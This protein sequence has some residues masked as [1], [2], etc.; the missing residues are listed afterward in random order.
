MKLINPIKNSTGIGLIEVLITTVVVAVG[1]LAIASLQG[2][3]MNSSG[4]NKTH[5]EAKALCDTKVEELRDTIIKAG[6]SGYDAI[7][8]SAANESITG[9]NEIFSR[10][11]VVANLPNPAS[12]VLAD[13]TGPVRKRISAT[14]SWA[15]GQV[16]VQ[17]ILAFEDIGASGLD[18]IGQ[19]SGID[20]NDPSTN[21]NSSEEIKPEIID[22]PPGQTDGSIYSQDGKTYLVTASGTKGVRVYSCGTLTP[23][24]HDLFTRR[25]NR[26]GVVG[27]EA[28][29]LFEKS[30]VD[31]SYCIPKIRFNGGVIIPIRGIVHS[32]ATDGN[33]GPLLDVNLFT[34]NAT[35]SGTYCIFDP[36]VGAKSAPYV[37]YV[38]GNCKFGPAGTAVSGNVPV[39]ECPNPTFSAAK[40]GPGGWRGKVGLLGVAAND[41]NVCFAEELTGEP[42]T[43][44]TAR[45]YYTRNNGLNEGINKP[46]SCHDFLIINGQN[47]NK[48]KISEECTDQ[49]A[50][51]GGFSLASKNIQ[52]DI[53][54]NNVFDPVINTGYCQGNPDTSQ[55]IIGT[56]EN[57]NSANASTAPE[58]TVSGG[59]CTAT[60]T[61][62]TCWLTTAE[63]SVTVSGSYDGRTASC[64]FDPAIASGCTLS[65]PLSDNP[66]YTI[67]GLIN[68]TSANSVSVSLDLSGIPC[69][70]MANGD[71]TY[72][73]S[74]TVT[75]T[76]PTTVTLA[77]KSS[78]IGTTVTP[79]TQT[80]TL[81]GASGTTITVP[82]PFSAEGGA[83]YT[84]S[85]SI[86]IGSLVDNL[87]TVTVA[88]DT[89]MGACTLTGSHSADT[90]DSYSC[91][92]PGG[93]NH[94]TIAISPPCSSGEDTMRY[95]ISDG[96]TIMDGG[97]LLIDL[98][99]VGGPVSKDITITKSQTSC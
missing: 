68:G 88:V 55:L 67:T 38:G 57:A 27:D 48:R 62:Y 33:N 17:S 6:A 72:S 29:E 71:G 20:M 79:T 5:A 69:T 53:T 15:S 80:V 44:D 24:E 12:A 64:S 93:S 23:F 58:V 40:V 43:L 46:Y 74:C 70:N 89:N 85:G 63:A 9:T 31:T 52:R 1:L 83:T 35:E 90:A 87:T 51:I 92:V 21:A 47:N 86:N 45:N 37:C 13:Q 7:A 22:L 94:L 95:E 99:N 42:A 76:D 59:N 30:T 91:T 50:A 8:S 18:A 82:D 84:V 78:V 81:S 73:Y 39:T 96:T 60:T 10:G 14:C 19:N 66:T 41:K 25:V 54:G 11:W 56:I 16:V 49:A 98:G 36:I 32:A 28:I 4:L 26:D 97:S 77:A 2:D 65:F 61:S 75:A 34:F 3:L